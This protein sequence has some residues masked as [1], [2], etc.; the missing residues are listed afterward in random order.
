[1]KY[2]NGKWKE[3]VEI[4][5]SGMNTTKWLCLYSYEYYLIR[6]ANQKY[7]SLNVFL[8]SCNVKDLMFMLESIFSDSLKLTNQQRN[9]V[10]V[11]DSL[12]AKNCV[13]LKN[14]AKR[15]Q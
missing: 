10:L 13:L 14:T 3:Y 12:T 5:L 15:I 11:T 6:P 7:K 9:S 1:M 8:S 2:G 4:P